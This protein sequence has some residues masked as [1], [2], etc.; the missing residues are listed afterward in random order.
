MFIE[1]HNAEGEPFLLNVEEIKSVR[2]GVDNLAVIGLRSM[3]YGNVIPKESYEEICN[4]LRSLIITAKTDE[5]G[6]L[7]IW[8]RISQSGEPTK[9]ELGFDTSKGPSD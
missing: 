7:E 3:T 2:R 5:S 4:A 9:V 8:K 6:I 1:L